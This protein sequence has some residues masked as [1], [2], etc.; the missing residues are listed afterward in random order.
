MDDAYNQRRLRE[1][2]GWTDTKIAEFYKVS[3]PYVGTL[4]KLLLLPT[5]IQLKVHRKEISVQAAIALTDLTPEEQK[6]VIAPEVPA[7][8]GAV[9]IP[10]TSATVIKRTREKKIEKGKKQARTLKELKDFLEGLSSEDPALKAF[11]ETFLKFVQGA[12]TDATMQKKL[13]G[14]IV[15][16]PDDPPGGLEATSAPEATTVVGSPV[17]MNVGTISAFPETVPFPVETEVAP[18]PVVEAA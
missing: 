6:A 16:V 17:G 13:K 4:K 1:E 8:P 9:P 18:F 15:G 3:P 12:Y 5:D 7:T 14:F 11:S 2:C 10:V